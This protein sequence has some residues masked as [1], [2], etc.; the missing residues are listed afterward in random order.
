[1]L[2]SADRAVRVARR[3]GRE[4]GYIAVQIAVPPRGRA[5]G[6]CRDPPGEPSRTWAGVGH[7]EGRGTPIVDVSPQPGT[8]QNHYSA[9]SSNVGDV[10]TARRAG[11]RHAVRATPST[12][13]VAAVSTTQS[14]GATS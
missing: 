14:C 11:T 1:M 3:L 5:P 13:T 8:S 6:R 9:L 2:A 4:C 12:T 7:T 10:R